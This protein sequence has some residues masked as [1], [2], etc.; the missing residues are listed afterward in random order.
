MKQNLDVLNNES[1]SV[2]VILGGAALT[3]KFVN[4]DCNS[5]YKGIV[6]Y[7]AKIAHTMSSIIWAN[8]S[9]ANNVI[10]L[11]LNMFTLIEVT[12]LSLQ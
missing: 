5:V 9:V 4:N 11:L 12:Q 1:I 8:E 10:K 6:V 3:P 2:P 7:L